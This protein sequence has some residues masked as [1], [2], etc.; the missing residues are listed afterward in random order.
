M[1]RI[2]IAISYVAVFFCISSANACYLYSDDISYCILPCV[3]GDVPA[4]IGVTP[5]F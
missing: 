2:L 5:Q 1:K 4:C 3:L